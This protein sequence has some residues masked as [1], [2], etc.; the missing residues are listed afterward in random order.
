ATSTPQFGASTFGSSSSVPAFGSSF[1]AAPAFG[2]TQTTTQQSAP[3]F[4]APQAAQAAPLTF[5][6]PQTTTQAAPTFGAQTTSQSPFSFS[7]APQ[8]AAPASGGFN[9]QAPA[10][11]G[12]PKPMSTGARSHGRWFREHHVQHRKRYCSPQNQDDPQSEEK[13]GG[14]PQY[15]PSISGRTRQNT[16]PPSLF[17]AIPLPLI[18]KTK[19]RS[20]S[21]FLYCIEVLI[22]LR[23]FLLICTL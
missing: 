12:A 10:A 9:F 15:P 6:A 1:G 19:C 23:F 4:G 8:P 11:S 3:A 2:S 16:I 20:K 5:G 18:K 13:V 7:G 14:G 22:I 17:L 21:H